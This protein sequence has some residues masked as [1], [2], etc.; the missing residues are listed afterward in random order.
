MKRVKW[1]N[2]SCYRTVRLTSAVSSIR[3]RLSWDTIN[4]A[5]KDRDTIN[6]N[7]HSCMENRSGHVNLIIC[8]QLHH[9]LIMAVQCADMTHYYS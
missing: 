1:D 4:K 5:L 2:L 7:Q 3:E 6:A 8:M 9:H